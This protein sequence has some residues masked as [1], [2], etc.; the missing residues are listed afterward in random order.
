M[1]QEEVPGHGPQTVEG[2]TE[3]REATLRRD[4]DRA[5]PAVLRYSHMG[6]NQLRLCPCQQNHQVH[7]A[8]HGS[9]PDPVNKEI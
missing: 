5:A 6:L 2:Q 4:G 1:E 7:E 3:V 8:R 9:F